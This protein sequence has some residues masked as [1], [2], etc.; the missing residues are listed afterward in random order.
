MID[1]EMIWLVIGGF[2]LFMGAMIGLTTW[3]G[4]YPRTTLGIVLLSLVVYVVIILAR[5]GLVEWLG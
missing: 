4:K 3:G 5:L 2:A 1:S